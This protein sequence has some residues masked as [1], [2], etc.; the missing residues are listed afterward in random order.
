MGLIKGDTR[1]LDYGSN[2]SGMGEPVSDY[3]SP[4]SLLKRSETDV[5]RR[6][7]CEVEEHMST[8]EA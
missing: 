1:S 6:L 5:H 7:C 8:H 3:S 2:A 4:H